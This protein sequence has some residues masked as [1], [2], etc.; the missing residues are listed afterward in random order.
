MKEWI[1]I[2]Y[3]FKSVVTWLIYRQRW[4]YSEHIIIDFVFNCKEKQKIHLMYLNM[5]SEKLENEKKIKRLFL[6]SLRQIND[7]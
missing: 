3:A 1:S 2:L 4:I 7:K 6:Y 5:I